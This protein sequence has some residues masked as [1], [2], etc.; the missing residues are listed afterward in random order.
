MNPAPHPRPAPGLPGRRSLLGGL[1]AGAAL[2][3][4]P[5]LAAPAHA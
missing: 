2:A 3:A 4:V 1:L 5:A